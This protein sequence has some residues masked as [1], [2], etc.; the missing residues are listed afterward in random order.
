M[1]ECGQWHL[2]VKALFEGRQRLP[3]TWNQQVNRLA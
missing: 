1:C 2:T 3:W